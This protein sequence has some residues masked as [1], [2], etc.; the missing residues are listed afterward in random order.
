MVVCEN[1]NPTSNKHRRLQNLMP[2]CT[3]TAS[4]SILTVM[5]LAETA[6]P[7]LSARFLSFSRSSAPFLR[8]AAPETGV[9][10]VPVAGEPNLASRAAFRSSG[11]RIFRLDSL[12][13][14]GTPPNF[15]ARRA[16]RCRMQI[17]RVW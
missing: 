5:T 1:K 4:H 11:V 2:D 13:L 9:A 7:N 6:S 16:S 10:A 3:A 12:S 14:V 8:P 15:S 17:Y